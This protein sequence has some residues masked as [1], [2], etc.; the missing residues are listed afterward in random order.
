MKKIHGLSI[1]FLSITYISALYA[2]SAKPALGKDVDYLDSSTFRSVLNQQFTGLVTGQSKNSIGNFASLDI[3]EP[4]VSFGA[5]TILKNSSVL[6]VS[7]SGGISD[8]LFALFNNSKLNTKV[9]LDVKL[10]FLNHKGNSITFAHESLQAYQDKLDALMDK[11]QLDSI[12]IAFERDRA[13]LNEKVEVLNQKLKD[14]IGLVATEHNL[15]KADSLH[16]EIAAM[17]LRYN[18]ARATLNKLE[19]KITR[20]EKLNQKLGIDSNNIDPNIK[21]L[22]FELGWLSIGYGVQNNSFKLFNAS[23]AYLDQ[24]KKQSFVSHEVSVQYS[25][26]KWATQSNK[27]FFWLMG[28]AFMYGDN[29]SDLNSKEITEVKNYGSNAN[30]RTSTTKYNVYEGDYEKGIKGIRLY[31]DYYKFLFK[32]N[33]IALHCL[34]EAIYKDRISPTYNSGVGILMSFKN[35]KDETSIVNVELYYKFLDLFKTIYTENNFFD[36]NEVGLR[37]SFPIQFKSN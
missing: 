7:A 23:A 25:K 29:L 34:A 14:L 17:Q 2:Q 15:K 28:A 10:N 22:G 30:D 11:Y 32:N 9:A 12:A 18:S 3:K 16:Y 8:G 20:L 33:F 27:S 4:S 35:S 21:V 36:R 1:A 6:T 31:G 13:D 37:F 19:P 26:Y 5:S 24:V